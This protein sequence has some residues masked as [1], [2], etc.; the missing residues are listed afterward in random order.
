MIRKMTNTILLV[1][2]DNLVCDVTKELLE[3]LDYQV[4]S[5]YDSAQTR[6]IIDSE[7][8]I[9]LVLLDLSL[10]DGNGL[11]LFPLMLD[12]RPELKIVICTGSTYDYNRENLQK[13]GIMAFLQ[14]PFNLDNLMQILEELPVQGHA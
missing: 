7:I 4:V 13:N 14:K 12:K 5:A 3:S 11:D 2:D 6:N 8:P 1:E 10:P 9:D